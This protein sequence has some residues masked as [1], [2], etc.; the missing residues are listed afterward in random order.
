MRKLSIFF[1]ENWSTSP[2]IVII[3]MDGFSEFALST[4]GEMA[5]AP[6]RETEVS[7]FES[8]RE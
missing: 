4:S 8:R 3:T 2:K 7:G 1:A 6:A 5:S